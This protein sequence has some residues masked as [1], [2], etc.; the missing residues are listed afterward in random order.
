MGAK[1]HKGIVFR[2]FSS[3]S[4]LHCQLHGSCQVIIANP[5]RNPAKVFEGL[6]VTKQK[7]LLPLGWKRHDKRPA[8]IAQT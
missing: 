5:S 8:R 1:G 7:A 3:F 4:F 2:P 6:H